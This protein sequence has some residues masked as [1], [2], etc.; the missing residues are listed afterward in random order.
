MLLRFF[1]SVFIAVLSCGRPLTSQSVYCTKLKSKSYLSRCTIIDLN[2]K[3]IRYSR[4]IVNLVQH[5]G[6][7]NALD[8]LSDKICFK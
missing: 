1:K 4:F 6:T 3:E 8:N 5:C 2:L 7:C